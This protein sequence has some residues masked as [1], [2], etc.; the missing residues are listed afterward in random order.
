MTPYTIR[1][2]NNI[3][4]L[5]IPE[6]YGV[7]YLFKTSGTDGKQKY[8]YILRDRFLSNFKK[9]LSFFGIQSGSD[10]VLTSKLSDSHP[11]AFGIYSTYNDI[12]HSH[13]IK[14]SIKNINSGVPWIFS[15]PSFFMNFKHFMNLSRDQKIVLTGEDVPLWLKIWFNENR[16]EV[17]QSY[18]M[19]E[20]LNIGIKKLNDDYYDFIDTH[21]KI[22]DRFIYSPYLC[23]FVISEN[24]FNEVHEGYEFSDSIELVGNRFKFL[25]R[26]SSI[27][28]INEEKISLAAL[29][30]KLQLIE[31]L[32]DCS[33]FKSR[34]ITEGFDEI[35]MVHTSHLSDKEIENIIIDIF[36]NVNYIPK[37]IIKV[38]NIPLTDMG[39]RDISKIRNEYRV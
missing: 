7:Y 11:Y 32:R 3:H 6:D 19:S 20:A 23:S 10:I 8:V 28:K 21:I 39:K 27:V 34:K 13:D 18:G 17:Y 29:Q 4:S 30:D 15:T 5:N 35:V 26:D 22:K 1:D 31:S 12:H 24:S 36:K 33:I 14:E 37:K 9:Y 38:E 25:E 2:I 16:I